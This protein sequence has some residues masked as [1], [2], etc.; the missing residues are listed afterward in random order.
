MHPH[1]THQS[2]K[3]KLYSDTFSIFPLTNLKL[4]LLQ[5]LEEV[6]I[7]RALS[8]QAT[9]PQHLLC[10][11]LAPAGTCLHALRGHTTVPPSTV[12]TAASRRDNPV[13]LTV[14]WEMWHGPSA[15]KS[16]ALKGTQA[17]I[18]C[19]EGSTKTHGGK[20]STAYCS[21][22]GVPERKKGKPKRK[23]RGGGGG[24]T[25]YC[26][27]LVMHDVTSKRPS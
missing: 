4:W 3:L 6:T 26:L 2:V 13:P 5:R 11:A 8:M 21:V 20:P 19:R 27:P 14:G 12:M 9:C 15:V 23:K 25:A 10:P 18:C 7:L 17:A 1:S 22:H 24:G 16:A